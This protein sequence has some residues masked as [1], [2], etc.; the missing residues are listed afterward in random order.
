MEGEFRNRYAFHFVHSEFDE[1][2]WWP[3]RAQ[4]IMG[5]RP[6]KYTSGNHHLTD[7]SWRH[8]SVLGHLGRA[9][10]GQGQSPRSPAFE[11]GVPISG[12]G[13]KHLEQYGGNQE[14]SE[15]R[16][17]TNAIGRKFLENRMEGSRREMV[18][19]F[20]PS[21]KRPFSECSF[22]GRGPQVQFV[23]PLEFWLF[24]SLV[25]CYLFH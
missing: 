15:G 3:I 20:L 2:L 7:N 23:T 5:Y 12:M 9:E 1:P 4:E 13:K 8:G 25:M 24:G 11:T 19:G 16:V 17:P 21:T 6:W 10:E 18:R 22:P 14:R